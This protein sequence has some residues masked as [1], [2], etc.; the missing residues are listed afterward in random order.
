MNF[1]K[2]LTIKTAAKLSETYMELIAQNIKRG[3]QQHS[4]YKSRY[5]LEED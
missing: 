2:S 3:Y 1:I 4:K 5:I